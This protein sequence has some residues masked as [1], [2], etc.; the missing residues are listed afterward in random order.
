MY[1]HVHTS[2]T[3]AAQEILQLH[4]LGVVDRLPPLD[5]EMGVMERKQDQ[6]HVGSDGSP[7]PSPLGAWESATGRE[8]ERGYPAEIVINNA[9]NMELLKI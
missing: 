8:A 9:M 4:L 1:T 3:N 2:G 7:L 6:I 5:A